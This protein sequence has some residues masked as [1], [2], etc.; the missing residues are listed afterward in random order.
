MRFPLWNRA[1]PI[2]C[3]NLTCE[4]WTCGCNI[5]HGPG[6]PADCKHN[7][8]HNVIHDAVKETLAAELREAGAQADTERAIPELGVWHF[9]PDANAEPACQDAVLEANVLDSFTT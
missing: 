9:K 5:G 1:D 8:A 4:G 2:A 6:H 3:A 7:R